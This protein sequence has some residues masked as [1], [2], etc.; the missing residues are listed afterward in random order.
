M[1]RLN[2]FFFLVLLVVLSTLAISADNASGS[3]TNITMKMNST[4]NEIL[5]M[6]PELARRNAEGAKQEGMLTIRGPVNFKFIYGDKQQLTYPDVKLVIYPIEDSKLRYIHVF[7]QSENMTDANMQA[8][9]H[10]LDKELTERGWQKESQESSKPSVAGSGIRDYATF[11][12]KTNQ[13][14][15]IEIVLTSFVDASVPCTT[16]EQDKFSPSCLNRFVRI[17]FYS[18]PG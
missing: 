4:I 8:F 3:V 17:G 2:L 6:N 5:A 14:N 7:P 13:A 11:R 12:I 10:R 18:V 16:D 9:L 1:Q 15:Q